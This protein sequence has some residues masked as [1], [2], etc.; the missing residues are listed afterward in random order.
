MNTSSIRDDVLS[1]GMLTGHNRSPKS[2]PVLDLEKS[3]RLSPASH[4]AGAA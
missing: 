1:P 2:R 4:V 3:F